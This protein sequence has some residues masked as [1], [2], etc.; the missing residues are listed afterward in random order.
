MRNLLYASAVL[1]LTF[2]IWISYLTY[3]DQKN[4]NE[5]K[6]NLILSHLSQANEILSKQKKLPLPGWSLIYYSK[7]WEISFSTGKYD[8]VS[9]WLCGK[10]FANLWI[11]FN[12]PYHEKCYK[13][14]VTR[15]LKQ[16]QIWTVIQDRNT[17]KTLLT[18]NTENSITK[19]YIN[20]I[21]ITNNDS[22]NFP[23]NPYTKYIWAKFIGAEIK[24]WK[25]VIIDNQWKWQQLTSE[26]YKNY[27]LKTFDT[28]ILKW[29]NSTA[30]I[31][32]ENQDI[33]KLSWDSIVKI[34]ESEIFDEKVNNNIFWLI[35]NLTY[36]VYSINNNS[37]IKTPNQTI[38]IRWDI[39]EWTSS[40]QNNNYSIS[41]K[42][43]SWKNISE[44]SSNYKVKQVKSI[45]SLIENNW[46]SADILNTKVDVE[47]MI[48][49]ENE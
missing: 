3:K 19:D 17:Y 7:N 38:G 44:K 32:F 43:Y 25:L 23:Y 24:N 26:N 18:W 46:L 37:S 2:S 40:I 42:T 47:N 16:Y 41:T 39:L 34:Q 29:K 27:T 33:L 4:Q 48:K 30:Y 35:G 5:S 14:S 31:K 12:E 13:Y 28:I 22:N 8:I 9:G 36:N 21:L 10:Q 45:D 1:I 11:N 49:I 20:D 6:N 15:D